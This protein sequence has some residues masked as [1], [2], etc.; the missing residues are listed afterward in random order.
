MNPKRVS[1]ESKAEFLTGGWYH[2]YRRFDQVIK[3]SAA[4]L[5]LPRQMKLALDTANVGW[6]RGWQD[7]DPKKAA[8]MPEGDS[9]LIPDTVFGTEREPAAFFYRTDVT[10]PRSFANRK[11]VVLYFPSIIARAVQVWVNGQPVAFD[12]ETY[13]DTVWRGP[14]YFWMNYDH[15]QRFD[16]TGLVQPGARNTIAFRVFKSF[17]HGGSYDRVF[18]LADPPPPPPRR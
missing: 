7:P 5:V 18:L 12:H 8:D 15:Q 17:D 2:K 9:T 10:V 16:V 4:S 14:D 1:K 11:Q 3:G 13:R 6:A